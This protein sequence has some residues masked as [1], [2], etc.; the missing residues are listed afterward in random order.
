MAQAL[1]SPGIG[2]GTRLNRRAIPNVTVRGH[3]GRER[4]F[5]QD[6][7]QGRTLLVAFTSIAH[8]VHSGCARKLA[9]V[10]NLLGGSAAQETLFL[11]ITVDPERDDEPSLARHAGQAGAG[12]ACS[13][14]GGEWLF[15]TA[16]PED[17]EALRTAF[18]VHRTLAP[19]WRGPKLLTRAELLR[20]PPKRAVMDCS[21]GLLRYGNEALDIW[22]GVPLRASAR[23]ISA[24]LT[25]VRGAPS[26]GRPA[27][28]RGGPAAHLIRSQEDPPWHG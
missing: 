24:R 15:L 5:Y 28:R 14:G 26:G 9:E 7:A 25:W 2:G 16:T 18:Y 11:S 20:L 13:A 12:A 17:V 19:V 1:A 21:M 22:G 3:D 27:R 10:R 8:D 23:D 6:L 4:R